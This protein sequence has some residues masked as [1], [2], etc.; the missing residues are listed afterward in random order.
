M[1]E[2]QIHIVKD[3]ET[4]EKYLTD[5]GYKFNVNYSITDKLL[6]CQA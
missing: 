5:H 6:D 1:V 3:I 4:T 2:S